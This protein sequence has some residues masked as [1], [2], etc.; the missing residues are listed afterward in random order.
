[1]NEPCTS[2]QIIH[3]WQINGYGS[4]NPA[5]LQDITSK[6]AYLIPHLP[7]SQADL[8]R[9][10]RTS[11]NAGPQVIIQVIDHLNAKPGVVPQVYPKKK[12]VT[13]TRAAKLL[14][15]WP[16]ALGLALAGRT[17]DPSTGQLP[18]ACAAADQQPPSGRSRDPGTVL[19]RGTQHWM[20][21]WD[22]SHCVTPG[23][24]LVE[25]FLH[26]WTPRFPKLCVNDFFARFRWY[27]DV[28][29]T[30]FVWQVEF[31]EFK[32]YIQMI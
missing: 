32:L 9:E 1:M 24:C 27:K 17:S 12:D 6:K 31:N 19:A 13:E 20:S 4:K 11:W 8:L 14:A 5:W 7:D 25:A 15:R 10:M 18:P 29:S 16:V 22:L 2:L 21:R 26:T 28:E 30:I 23:P 3:P